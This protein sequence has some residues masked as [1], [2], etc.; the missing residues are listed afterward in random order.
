MIHTILYARDHWLKEDG[1]LY[2]SR[3]NMYIS[4]FRSQQYYE[5]NVLF[6]EDVYGFDFSPLM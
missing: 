4:G 5:D 1:K 3:A 2:P 6:W